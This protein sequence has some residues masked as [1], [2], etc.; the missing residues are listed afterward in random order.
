MASQLQNA[1]PVHERVRLVIILILLFCVCPCVCN[2]QDL[3]NE[4]LYSHAAR[5]KNIFTEWE[6]LLK[7]SGT[8]GVQ[9]MGSGCRTLPSS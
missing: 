3:G 1:Q 6:A 5:K 2:F 4:M 8:C 7:L 9:G